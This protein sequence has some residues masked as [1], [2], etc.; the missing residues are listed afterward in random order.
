MSKESLHDHARAC[1][2]A[3]GV[4]ETLAMSESIVECF[5]GGEIQLDNGDSVD[6]ALWPNFPDKP[7]LVDPSAVPR[8]GIASTTGRA[9][10]VHAIAHIEYNAI[11]LAWDAIYRFRGLP[12]NY[13]RD[14]MQVA[15]DETRHFRLLRARLWELGHEYGDF[16]AHAGLWRMADQTRH[17]ALVRMAVVPRVLEARGLDVTPGMIRKL[18]Q[19]GDQRT[20][21]ILNIIYEDEIGHVESGSRWF[22]YLCEVRG[23]EPEQTF[24][25]LIEQYYDGRLRGPFNEPAREQAGF[26]RAEL[27]WLNT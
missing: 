4:D 10:L 9:A 23:L 19:V 22:R 25:D 17:D 11:H 18:A 8:R 20:A 16:D 15:A 26:S 5:A 1:L 21:D 13:Y 24:R 27:E 12:E 6:D 14:W 3:A 7:R 2:L